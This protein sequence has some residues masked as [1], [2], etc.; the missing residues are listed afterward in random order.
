MVSLVTQLT[1]SLTLKYA[2]GGAIAISSVYVISIHIFGKKNLNRDDPTVVK[3][4]LAGA[5]LGTIG[6][7]A[8][9]KH[10]I[11]YGN[12]DRQFL[13]LVGL[14]SEGLTAA[15][16]STVGLTGTLFMGP[17]VQ[18]F[19]Q[20]STQPDNKYEEPNS[21]LLAF[22]TLVAA[23]ITEEIVYRACLVPILFKFYP[24]Q[25]TLIMTVPLFFGIAHTHHL[26]EKIFILKQDV[27]LS[28][29]QTVVQ[30]AYTT[31]FGAL[32]TF[33]YLRTAHLPAIIIMHSMC[34]YF[35]LPNFIG[36]C[37]EQNKIK[38]Y[39]MALIYAAGLFGFGFGCTLIKAEEFDNIIF[40]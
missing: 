18:S 19:L 3:T 31:I 30:L 34:N 23:P 38:K 24:N 33:I 35:G 8:I 17:I 39:S 40:Y 4:R 1:E 6:G 7:V 29:I 2:V 5:V 22:R 26:F 25:T 16:L 37:N 28:V 27:T 14:R 13:S 12:I 36:V 9:M 20:S 21:L 32:S 15:V 11:G 10:L